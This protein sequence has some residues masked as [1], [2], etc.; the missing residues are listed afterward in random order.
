MGD[1]PVGGAEEITRTRGQRASYDDVDFAYADVPLHAH[2]PA[3]CRADGQ[4]AFPSWL[5]HR[6]ATCDAFVQ[7]A[8]RG[9]L[10]AARSEF[11][12]GR[13][14]FC[15]AHV[16]AAHAEQRG[17]RS[18]RAGT[19]SRRKVPFPPSDPPASKDDSWMMGMGYRDSIS[20][21]D[22]NAAWQTISK[23]C[24]DP[25]WSRGLAGFSTSRASRVRPGRL[26]AAP[27]STVRHS[28]RG[29]MRSVGAGLALSLTMLETAPLSRLMTASFA[30]VHIDAGG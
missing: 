9:D 18:V 14:A 8:V 4:G 13:S 15:N 26:P 27:F 1:D 5:F 7:N 28:A 23:F 10:D 16:C 19:E 6:F 29:V 24:F 25:A 3:L 17:V 2:Q 11:A 30:G 20:N 22:S 12:S 21:P